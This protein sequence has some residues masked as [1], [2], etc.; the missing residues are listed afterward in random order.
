MFFQ[1]AIISNLDILIQEKISD[2]QTIMEIVGRLTF[3]QL[4]LGFRQCS[5]FFQPDAIKM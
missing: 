3:G 5:S 4:Q 1:A 2:L